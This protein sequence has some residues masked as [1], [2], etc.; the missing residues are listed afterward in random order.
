MDIKNGG[1]G[2]RYEDVVR[3][4]VSIGGDTDTIAAIPRDAVRAYG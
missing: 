3:N 1:T 2:S 4:V